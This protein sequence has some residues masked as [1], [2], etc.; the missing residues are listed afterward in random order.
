MIL[1]TTYVLDNY[2][3]FQMRAASTWNRAFNL[4]YPIFKVCCVHL[5][6]ILETA[7]LRVTYTI[8]IISVYLLYGKKRP[9]QKA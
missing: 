8:C 5:A 7:K 9:F 6:S 2:P 1:T 3:P 4:I